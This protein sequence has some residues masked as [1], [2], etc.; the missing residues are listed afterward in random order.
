MACVCVCN[1]KNFPRC[2]EQNTHIIIQMKNEYYF[3][4]SLCLSFLLSHAEITDLNMFAFIFN[5]GWYAAWSHDRAQREKKYPLTCVSYRV[6]VVVVFAG[7]GDG[8]ELVSSRCV[9]LGNRVFVEQRKWSEYEVN[10]EEKE[11][12]QDECIE[13]N[14]SIVVDHQSE[15]IIVTRLN[16]YRWVS[17]IDE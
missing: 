10:E 7:G 3:S 16:R 8:V 12:E 1:A 14:E 17:V 5:Q 9:Y 13:P 2:M 4:V 15:N 11:Q 6:T